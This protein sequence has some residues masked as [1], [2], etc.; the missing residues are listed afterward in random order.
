ME[1]KKVKL[2]L[3]GSDFSADPFFLPL[4]IAGVLGGMGLRTTGNDTDL[5]RGNNSVR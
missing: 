2:D 4:T 3:F 5:R 1:K